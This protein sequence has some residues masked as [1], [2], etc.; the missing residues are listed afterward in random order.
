MQENEGSRHSLLLAV[1]T[2]FYLD[3]D[4]VQKLTQHCNVK[5]EASLYAREQSS[6]LFL[7]RHLD[8]L[9]K[10]NGKSVVYREATVVAVCDGH[11]DVMIGDL[12]MEKRVHLA[13]LPVWRSDFD[14][15]KQTLTM[16]WRKGVDTSTG[17]Q[18]SWSITDDDDDD[19]DEGYLDEELLLEEML[20]AGDAHQQQQDLDNLQSDTKEGTVAGLSILEQH[21]KKTTSYNVPLSNNPTHQK[22]NPE[23]AAA[24]APPLP[25]NRPESTQSTSAKRASLVRSRLSDSTAYSTEQGYQTVKALDKIRVALV[26]DMVRTPPLIRILAVNPF[27]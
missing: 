25:L 20:Q 3:R 16:Y 21:A 19:D 14:E 4:T 18:R 26:I 6:L 22:Q 5:K 1:D 23:A 8:K 9:A 15:A 7:G 10:Q 17:I 13:N 27:A 24:A 2:P 11:M 12:N